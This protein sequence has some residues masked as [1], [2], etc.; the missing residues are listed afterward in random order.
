MN[1]KLKLQSNEEIPPRQ[2]S[3]RAQA[4]RYVVSVDRQIKS[5]YADLDHAVAEAN[6]ISDAFPILS[7]KIT[8]SENLAVDQL[9][10][11]MRVGDPIG[12]EGNFDGD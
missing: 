1:K 11:E 9:S 2:L 6:R 8:D 10:N 12:E 7:V 5:S 3:R 4:A